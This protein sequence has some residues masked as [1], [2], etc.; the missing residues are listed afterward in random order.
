MAEPLKNHFGPEI[1]AAIADDL[2]RV[3]PDFDRNGFLRAS[4][5]GYEDLELTPRARHI[6]GALAKYLPP[7]RAVAM[8]T[9]MAALGPELESTEDLGGM[10]SFRYLPYV[11]FVA[12]EGLDDYDVAMRAQY[13]LTKRFSA[14]FSIRSYLDAY[15]EETLR[16]LAVWAEDPNPHVRR[17]V[18]E[19]T[20]PRLPWAP[21]LRRFQEDPAPVLEL[22]ELLKDDGDEYVRR[23]VANNLNDIA[24]DH[25]E[26][27]VTTTS[28]WWK[29][30]DSDQQRMIRHALRSLIKAG[31]PGALAVIGFGTDSPARVSSAT[32]EPATVAIGDSIRLTAVLE[33]PSDEPAGALVDFI[34]HFVKA[35]GSTSPKVFKGRETELAPGSDEEITRKISLAQFTTRTHY[36]GTHRFEVQLNG[37]AVAGEDFEV[38][39]A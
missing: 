32:V 2:C 38:L 23:S 15:P 30:A 33:N 34:V 11:F 39:P 7:D 13:E 35:D 36:P 20:R 1:P 37:S 21:R 8:E 6:A 10:A 4:L 19:G 18:S 24:K 16:R 26:V 31:D 9:I 3:D 17:L 25:P 22:L 12:F 28:R 14:E 5:E 27:V 29:N